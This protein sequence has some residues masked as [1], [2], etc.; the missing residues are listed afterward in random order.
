MQQD[1]RNSLFAA[2]SLNEV[3]QQLVI[4]ELS[5]LRGEQV[6]DRHLIAWERV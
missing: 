5:H 6:S 3:R 1:F 4:F 2:Y